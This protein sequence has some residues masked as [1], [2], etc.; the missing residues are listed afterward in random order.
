MQECVIAEWTSNHNQNGGTNQA[1]LYNREFLVSLRDKPLSRLPPKFLKDNPSD[2]PSKL[3]KR[4]SR[5]GIRNRLRRRG[6]RL[7]T[8]T[9]T[10]TNARSLCNKFDE[11]SS[12]AKYDSDYRRSNIIFVTESWLSTG[13]DPEIYGFETIKLDT[14][15][16]KTEKS[17][18]GGLIMFV[19]K[20]WATNYTVREKIITPDFEILSVSFRPHYLPREFTQVSIILTYVPGPDNNTAAETITECV[21][22]AVSRSADQ[23]VLLLGDFNKCDVSKHLPNFDQV[24]TIPTHDKGN[25]LD[26]CFV[27]IKDSYTVR[28]SPPLGRFD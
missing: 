20:Q 15:Q 12:L 5:G 27:N 25:I 2:I 16:T 7:P 9:V 17:V 11:L 1:R 22:R 18:G 21:N 4:G 28:L 8:P 13:K 10:F 3:K 24:V 19:N 14:D 26:K 6:P 23:P